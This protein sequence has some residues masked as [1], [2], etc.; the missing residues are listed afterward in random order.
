MQRYTP[1]HSTQDAPPRV[2]IA[3]VNFPAVNAAKT[4]ALQFAARRLLGDVKFKELRAQMTLFRY[5]ALRI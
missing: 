2:P 5:I 3:N 4:P 1:V